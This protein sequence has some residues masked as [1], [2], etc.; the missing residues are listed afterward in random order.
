MLFLLPVDR[1]HLVLTNEYNAFKEESMLVVR[2]ENVLSPSSASDPL[3]S[4]SSL[5][6]TVF[7]EATIRPVLFTKMNFIFLLLFIIMTDALNLSDSTINSSTGVDVRAMSFSDLTLADVKILGKSFNQFTLVNDSPDSAVEDFIL[8]FQPLLELDEQCPSFRPLMN[9]VAL[10]IFKKSSFGANF[11]LYFG[12]GLSIFDMVTDTIMISKYAGNG[13]MG[14]AQSLL[15]MI[16]L[17]MLFQL[18]LSW[19][20]HMNMGFKIL[21]L[22]FFFT[23][24]CL[25]P[26][27]HAYRV[28]SGQQKD[29]LATIDART[30]MMYGKA[31]ELVFEA[32][33]GLLLQLYAFLTLL[34]SSSFAIFSIAISSMTTAFSVSVMYFDKDTDPNCRKWNPSFYGVF[35]DSKSARGVAFFWLFAFS[36]AHVLSKALGVALFLATFGGSSVFIYYGAELLVYFLVKVVQGDLWAWI[37]SVGLGTSVG[38]TSLF[39]FA[40]KV[41][42]DFTGFL[43]LRHPYDLGKLIAPFVY[44]GLLFNANSMYSTNMLVSLH[45]FSA[46]ASVGCYCPLPSSLIVLFQ[47]DCTSA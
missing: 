28:A 26:G 21:L 24:T 33:P 46:R 39:R 11:R 30:M 22:E 20:Q 45:L 4:I 31:L 42:A 13:N 29:G 19:F 16:G 47:E 23:L 27:V 2:D 37:P 12:A 1:S 34:N 15:L 35:P 25:S 36:L 18:V 7:K 41:M 43:Q 9:H 40:G 3:N 8:Q 14:Y 5:P 17:N 10:T 32:V 6:L 38:L 44:L